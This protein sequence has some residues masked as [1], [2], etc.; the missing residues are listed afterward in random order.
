MKTISIEFIDSIRS[1]G[2]EAW[3]A[4]QLAREFFTNRQKEVGLTHWAKNFPDVSHAAWAA[5]RPPFFTPAQAEGTLVEIKRR[6]DPLVDRRIAD[7][8]RSAWSF[9][10]RLAFVCYPLAAH[11]EQGEQLLREILL[12]AVRAVDGD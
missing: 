5:I 7:Q 2:C 12:K 11:A 4:D 10:D 9:D 1:P 3:P 8:F 6:L